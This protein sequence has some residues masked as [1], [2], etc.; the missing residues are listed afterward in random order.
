[1]RYLATILAMGMLSSAAMA[2]VEKTFYSSD[3][4][5]IAYSGPFDGK[6]IAWFQRDFCRDQGFEKAV[7]SKSEFQD[8][9][10]VFEYITCSRSALTETFTSDDGRAILY[11]GPSDGLGLSRFE[12]RFCQS[13][14]YQTGVDRDYTRYLDVVVFHSLTCSE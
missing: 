5:T 7:D 14:G 8:F 1:M 3:E 13:K 11:F 12:D 10:L 9:E 2:D 6:G 4:Q